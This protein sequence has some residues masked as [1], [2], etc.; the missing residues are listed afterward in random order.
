[1][2]KV[3]FLDTHTKNYF[4]DIDFFHKKSHL[5]VGIRIGKAIR[6]TGEKNKFL[7]E[8]LFYDR[9]TSENGKLLFF[10]QWN[11]IGRKSFPKR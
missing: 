4:C 3:C 2:F 1:M 9:F 11:E 5:R 8:A 7:Q 10:V 6:C